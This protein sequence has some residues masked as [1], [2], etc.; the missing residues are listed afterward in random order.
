MTTLNSVLKRIPLQIGLAAIA[1]LFAYTAHAELQNVLVN[2]SYYLED[3]DR[4]VRISNLSGTRGPI[5]PELLRLPQESYQE[6]KIPERPTPRQ[7]PDLGRVFLS[8]YVAVPQW[9][10]HDSGRMELMVYADGYPAFKREFTKP[11]WHTCL[12]DM[13]PWAGQSIQL[14]FRPGWIEG[15]RKEVLIALPRVL[16]WHGPCYDGLGGGISLGPS[17]HGFPPLPQ[18]QSH[19]MA[20]DAQR[21]G[22]LIH[23]N[24]RSGRTEK[25]LV[26]RVD[27]LVPSTVLMRAEKQTTVYDLPTGY[28]WLP[29]PLPSGTDRWGSLAI[30]DGA[31]EGGPLDL[32]PNF[33]IND[34]MRLYF[35]ARAATYSSPKP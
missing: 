23:V 31:V 4:F 27:C 18:V 9:R 2:G 20:Q 12:V 33:M 30:L 24:D 6:A 25:L 11:G 17:Y 21:S 16:A 15:D 14:R 7:Y 1:L 28:H 32:I 34:P 8:F 13:G 26:A 22:G 3:E 19:W 5:A 10:E 29:I 35:I